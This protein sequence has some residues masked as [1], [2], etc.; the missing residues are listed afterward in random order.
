VACAGVFLGGGGK[1]FG[2]AIVLIIAECIWV[3][4]HMYPFFYL[5]N[6][7]DLLRVDDSEERMGLDVTNHGGAA[8]ENAGAEILAANMA[9]SRPSVQSE[10]I[11]R[12]N[13][14]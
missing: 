4:G 6:A 2:A 11:E 7:M 12:L 10:D 8:Y 9:K 3:V 14:R 13:A 1:L 5:M